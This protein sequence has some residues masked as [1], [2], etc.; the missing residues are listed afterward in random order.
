MHY[1]QRTAKDIAD[2]LRTSIT[3]GLGG[4]EA[5]RRQEK[6]GENAISK[7]KKAPVIIK[8]LSYFFDIFAMLLLGAALVSFVFGGDTGPRDALVILGIIFL[9]STIGFIQEYRAEKIIETLQKVLPKKAVVLRE[10]KESEVLASEI[11]PGDVLILDEGDDIPADA[12]IVEEN[13]LNT[14]DF[15]LTGESVPQEKFSQIIKKEVGLTDIDNMVFA[16]TSVASGNAKAIVI[17]TG[18]NTEFGKIA[19]VTQQIEDEKSPL[20]KELSKSATKV[21]R[22][23]IIIGIII[24]LINIFLQKSFSFSLVFALSLAVAMVPE[25]LPAT[26]SV[27]LALAVK[28]M[29][30]RKAL[31]KKLSAVETLGSATVICSD[32]T[33]TITKNEMTV[34]EVLADFRHFHIK[35]IGY[36]PVGDFIEGEAK[37]RILPETL[38]TLLEAGILCTNAKLIPPLDKEEQWK[39]LG[40]PT[41]GSII[42]LAEKAGISKKGLEIK[43]K[44]I[45]EIPFTSERKIMTVVVENKKGLFAYCKGAPNEVLDCC[46]SIQIGKEVKSIDEYKRKIMDHVD[47]YA[48]K[49]L[50]VLAIAYKSVNDRN[51]LCESNIE[52]N[53]TFLGLIAMI[54]P[55]KEGVAEAVSIAQKAGI[56]VIM[57]TGDYGLTASAVASRVG[58]VKDNYSVISGTELLKME[59]TELSTILKS[60]DV[61]FARTAPEQKIRIVNVLQEQG[62]I[63]AV[64]G[65]GVNDAPALKKADIGVAMGIAGTDVSKEASEVILL[66]DNFKTI[67]AAVE[68]GRIVYDNLKKFVHYIFSSN[69]GELFSVV[70]GIILGVPM[71]ILAIQILAVDLGT[72]VLPSLVLAV[73]QKDEDVMNR[74][75]RNQKERLLNKKMILGFFYIG[76]VMGVGAAVAF[77]ITVLRDGWVW[78]QDWTGSL[79]F[80][81]TSV[82]YASL[83][84]S[85]IVNVFDTHSGRQSILK[86]LFTNWYLIG[87]CFCSM[88]MLS[89]FLYIPFFQNFLETRSL[90]I[91]EIISALSV[92]LAALIS[93]KIKHFFTNRVKIIPQLKRENIS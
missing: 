2:E 41:E 59:D 85:Q 77:T 20:Q 4:N 26:V 1:Y 28:R 52:N 42:V 79:Y 92:G 11:I 7:E 62:Q 75:P 10:G 60:K 5:K 30:K 70:A 58:I 81:A 78:G 47:E 8:F 91:I 72:D 29:A 49:G 9:N 76:I 35:G 66:D 54:D 68:E 65:D 83:V 56:K 44:E 46:P 27:A 90:G 43:N 93:V 71:P 31:V 24:F 86:S 21:A 57:I 55:P 16:G 73:D 3:Y 50:R 18:M 80:K 69:V 64:T 37:I 84:F 14:N 89:S 32:K 51:N 88:V 22:I 61:V 67:V 48:K 23:T 13:E 53:L 6:Y 45:F 36:E 15:T 63:V 39:I 82:T 17:A 40:D 38:I 12:R 74:P 87:A 33:G 25:G 19:C 34:K